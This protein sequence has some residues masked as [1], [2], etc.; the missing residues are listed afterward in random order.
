MTRYT[1]FWCIYN[2][3][4]SAWNKLTEENFTA[5]HYKQI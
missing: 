1:A 3:E 4:L 2:I 5:F